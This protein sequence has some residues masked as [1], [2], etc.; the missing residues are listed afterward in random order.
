MPSC[1]GSC[2]ERQRSCHLLSD[3]WKLGPRGT[4][5]GPCHTRE[6][7]NEVQIHV[8]RLNALGDQISERVIPKDGLSS[9]VLDDLRCGL[10]GRSF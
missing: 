8:S 9:N 3:L 1:L 2:R 5:C 6:S 10:N 4:G 7:W